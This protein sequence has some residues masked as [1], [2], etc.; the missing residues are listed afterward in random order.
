MASSHNPSDV[1][2]PLANAPEVITDTAAALTVDV[3]ADLVGAELKQ[4]VDAI[5][6]IIDAYAKTGEFSAEQAQ[7]I[8]NALHLVRVLAQ[9]SRQIGRVLGG[10]AEPPQQV[11][12]M[13][14][15]AH[16][17][18]RQ[19]DL[20][21]DQFNI[22]VR[23]IIKPTKVIADAGLIE[24]L[25]HSVVGWAIHSGT[26]VS[27]LV[28]SMGKPEHPVLAA[29]VRHQWDADGLSSSRASDNGLGWQVIRQLAERM[30]LTATRERTKD[31]YI[32][33]LDFPPLPDID[34]LLQLEGSTPQKPWWEDAQ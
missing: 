16:E 13:D 7:E 27:F 15:L 34:A 14:E 1:P 26:V 5:Q 20:V 18:L 24:E 6:G 30:E 2:A 21:F 19:H 31:G 28:Q 3:L 10:H 25:L 9:R 4:P 11:V 32:L 17:V 22:S 23:S 33:T 29:T 8:L 12:R